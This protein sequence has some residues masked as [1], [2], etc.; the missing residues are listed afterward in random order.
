MTLD[1]KKEFADI[2]ALYESQAQQKSFNALIYGDFG[3]GKTNLTVTCRL[4]VH[5]DSF[6]PGGVKT[7]RDEIK[8]GKVLADVRY[9]VEDPMK[10]TA[11]RLWDTEYARRKRDGYFAQIGTYIIDSATTWASAAMDVI[12][13]K[14]GRLGGPPF[15]QD[16]LPAM[17]MIENAIKDITTL[18]C[19]VILTAHLDVDKDEATGRLFV[20]PLFVGKLKQ[21]IPLLFDELYCAQTKNTSA[22]TVYSLLTR[23]DGIF[24]ARTR[25]GKGGIFEANEKPDIKVLLKKAGYP[26][27][28]KPF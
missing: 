25:L 26:T 10:P 13:Q 9:E 11:F 8:A 20:G 14:A 17:S 28:D 12:L 16:Y 18:P 1:I 27:D 7:V 5:I 2:R 15:Q 22:G 6:D 19:D 4:P 21:R 23:S 24:K 3:T